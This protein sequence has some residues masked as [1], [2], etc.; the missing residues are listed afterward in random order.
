MRTPSRLVTALLLAVVVAAPVAGWAEAPV[1]TPVDRA[2]VAALRKFLQE[3][4]Q[5]PNAPP[6]QTLRYASASV[7]LCE[8]KAPWILV[9]VAGKSWCRTGGCP[10]LVIAREPGGFRVVSRIAITRPPV[11]V[12]PTRTKGCLDLGVTVVGGGIQRPYQAVLPF[13]GAAYPRNPTI[14]PSRRAAGGP[15]GVVAIPAS[16]V[17]R[18]VHD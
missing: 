13:D 10:T 2:E 9:H 1:A 14:A 17:N 3:T 5:L 16:E 12:L 15:A 18:P 11:T 4:L 6:D 7:A 8:G